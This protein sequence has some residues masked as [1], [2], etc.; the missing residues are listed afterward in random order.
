MRFMLHLRSWRPNNK[1]NPQARVSTAGARV[2]SAGGKATG[3]RVL[4]EKLGQSFGVTAAI[5]DSENDLEMLQSVRVACAMGNAGQ[6]TKAVAHFVMPTN[7][8]SPP[9]V[10]AL[11]RSLTESLDSRAAAPQGAPARKRPHVFC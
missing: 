1:R 2:A 10:V 9:G 6:K 7:R 11:L 4:L 5:G 8:D 3:L